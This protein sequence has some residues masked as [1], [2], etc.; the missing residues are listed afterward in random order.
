MRDKSAFPFWWNPSLPKTLTKMNPYP[1]PDR[2]D[3]YESSRSLTTDNRRRPRRPVSDEQYFSAGAG[4]PRDTSS[5]PETDGRYH[6]P[7]PS[8]HHPRPGAH[9]V[10]NDDFLNQ[11]QDDVSAQSGDYAPPVRAFYEPRSYYEEH[12]EPAYPSDDY[13]YPHVGGSSIAE[14]ERN[15]DRREN[16]TGIYYQE[17]MEERRRH[18]RSPS[19]NSHPSRR[20]HH[21]H[22]QPH[23]RYPGEPNTHHH[24][25]SQPPLSPPRD[26]NKLREEQEHRLRHMDE[27]KVAQF[28]SS[29][30][31]SGV[32]S[33]HSKSRRTP[34]GDFESASSS[35]A[36]RA[37]SAASSAQKKPQAMPMI[38]I[39]PGVHVRLRGAAETRDCIRR[40]EYTPATCFACEL[41]IFCI[42][43]ASF[44]L[45]PNC[46]VVNPLGDGSEQQD[47]MMK[48]GVG[49]GFTFDELQRV[50]LEILQERK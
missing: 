8:Y 9:Y 34:R 30:A 36:S 26:Y 24:L 42:S 48:G 1:S 27:L 22:V 4:D 17:E 16:S 5:L 13:D 35:I 2:L 25:E 43:N 31:R 20:S 3:R 23:H 7:R 49:L 41:D 47:A 32:G 18:S 21:H 6:R 38:E 46:R 29:S 12:E 15:Y 33:V 50:Q 45:C 11:E 40:D 44:V 14:E 19:E 39:S 28:E 10:R 37:S